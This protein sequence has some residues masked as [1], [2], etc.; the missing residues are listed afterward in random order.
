M[1]AYIIG[2]FWKEQQHRSATLLPQEVNTEAETLADAVMT[3]IEGRFPWLKV[4]DYGLVLKNTRTV[5]REYAE[6]FIETTEAL[7]RI[8]REYAAVA[9]EGGA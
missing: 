6:R 5:T 8:T 2:P 4:T 7:A 1:N 3:Y 9:S